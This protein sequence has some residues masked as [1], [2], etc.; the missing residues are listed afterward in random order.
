MV[1]TVY[2][3]LRTKSRSYL[4]FTCIMYQKYGPHM[5]HLVIGHLVYYP[6]IVCLRELRM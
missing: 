3:Y 2:M 5:E 4:G 1:Y 6:E